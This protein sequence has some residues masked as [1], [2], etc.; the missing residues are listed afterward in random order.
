MNGDQCPYFCWKGDG[1]E[2]VVN[3]L[4]GLFNEKKFNFKQNSN[5]SN[6]RKCLLRLT[7][8]SGFGDPDLSGGDFEPP[9]IIL[10]RRPRALNVDILLQRT[11]FLHGS[12]ARLLLPTPYEIVLLVYNDLIVPISTKLKLFSLQVAFL[13]LNTHGA[14]ARFGSES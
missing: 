5:E 14:K 1:V 4:D 12:I 3:L 7:Y 8:P 13:F 10:N 6:G 2:G 9:A 11:V